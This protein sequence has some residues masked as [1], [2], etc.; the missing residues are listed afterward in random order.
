M[1]KAI[2]RLIGFGAKGIIKGSLAALYQ[3]SVII[4]K[5]G[6]LFAKLTS[7]AMRP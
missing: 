1:I 3:S 6:S 2:L 5:S 7:K 4:I